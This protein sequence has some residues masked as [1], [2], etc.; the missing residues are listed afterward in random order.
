VASRV[1]SGLNATW[2]TLFKKNESVC[3]IS[4]CFPPVSDAR[5]SI[6]SQDREVP[7]GST[8]LQL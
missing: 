8:V 2:C 5:P 4:A 7:L 1:P 3:F 6:R